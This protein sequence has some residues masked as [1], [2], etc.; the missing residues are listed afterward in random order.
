MHVLDVQMEFK[1]CRATAEN[2]IRWLSKHAKVVP[3][4]GGIQALWKGK[5]EPT[6]AH[7][8][9]QYVDS[10]LTTR[11]IAGLVGC[12][13]GVVVSVLGRLKR[14][15]RLDA[16]ESRIRAMEARLESHLRKR[17]S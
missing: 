13:Q 10:G 16:M 14:Q 2:D 6:K 9:R 17:Q 1:V 12:S 8:I 5:P 7:L 4:R 3:V 11:E 15:P